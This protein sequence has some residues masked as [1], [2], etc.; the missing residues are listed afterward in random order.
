MVD[1]LASGAS[2]GNNMEVRVLSSAPKKKARN[3]LS[4]FFGVYLLSI[5]VKRAPP[6]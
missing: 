3:I 6:I 4:F 1:A 5:K 2:V